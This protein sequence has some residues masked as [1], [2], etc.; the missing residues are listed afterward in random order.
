MAA[1]P[2]PEPAGPNVEN[3]PYKDRAQQLAAQRAW[4]RKQTQRRRAGR[5]KVTPESTRQSNVL[6]RL[7]SVCLPSAYAPAP[8]IKEH[9]VPAGRS[10]HHQLGKYYADPLPPS[11][12]CVLPVRNIAL[13]SLD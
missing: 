6:S 7:S 2:E 9:S 11:P 8:K 13:V 4:N 5:A 3:Y 1:A 12:R 10:P